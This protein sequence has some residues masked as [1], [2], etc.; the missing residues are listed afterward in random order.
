MWNAIGRMFW[1]LLIIVGVTCLFVWGLDRVIE[2]SKRSAK[3]KILEEHARTWIY[4]WRE[5]DIVTIN[6]FSVTGRVVNVLAKQLDVMYQD[7]VGVIHQRMFNP[8]D[9]EPVAL[10]ERVNILEKKR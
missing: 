8:K 5:G 10:R 6:G 4:D 9:V 1:S 7:S 2:W 3:Q